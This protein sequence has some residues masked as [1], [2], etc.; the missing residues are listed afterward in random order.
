MANQPSPRRR[1]QFRLRTLMIG[2]TLLAIPCGYVGWQLKWI[3]ERHDE[4]AKYQTW[5]AVP[6]IQDNP[7]I[8]LKRTKAPWPLGW[9][10]EDGMYLI[11]VPPSA[12]KAETERLI[13]L[14][15]EAVITDGIKRLWP[16]D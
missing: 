15:P 14:F 13:S 16:P 9:L 8:G 6:I 11:A 1:F 2:V 10:G 7:N 5:T 4:A 12:T 3:R